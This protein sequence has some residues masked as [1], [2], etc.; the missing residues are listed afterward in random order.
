MCLSSE[1]E[2]WREESFAACSVSTDAISLYVCVYPP[3]DPDPWCCTSLSTVLHI[4]FYDFSVYMFSIYTEYMLSLEEFII[5]IIIWR[6]KMEKV[7]FTSFGRRLLWT[8]SHLYHLLY[9]ETIY[10]LWGEKNFSF[11]DGEENEKVRITKDVKY[12]KMFLFSK[13]VWN[14]FYL[15]L[16]SNAKHRRYE[17]YRETC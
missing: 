10:K 5:F 7:M 14:T 6:W 1:Q 13:D 11:F 4:F 3:F 8:R 17:E 15:L 12:L 16:K 9:L 2:V